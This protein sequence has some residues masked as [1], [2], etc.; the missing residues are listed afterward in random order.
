MSILDKII[1]L[2]PAAPRI[3]IYGKPGIGKSTLASQFPK[4]LFL[5]TE[6][7]RLDGINAVPTTKTFL[8]F[9]ENLKELLAIEDFPY[10]TIVIDS[11]SKL[12]AQITKHIIDEETNNGGNKNKVTTLGAACG[13]YGKGYERAQSIHRAVKAQLDK[14]VDRG[15]AVVFIAHLAITK[16]KA[17]DS[18][19]YDIYSI[20]MNHDKSREVYIDDVDAVLFGRLQSFT[21]TLDSGKNIVKS[22]EQRILVA[23]VNDV[24]VAKNRFSMPSQIPMEFEELAKYIP[25]YN[26]GETQ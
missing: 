21:D 25:F 18:D 19:D 2:K 7:P 8:E 16:Y 26:Q 4:P 10:E 5:L 14:F 24:N 13:G 12:D 6:D 23:S 9:W 1:T 3:T 20:I 22:T 15:I 11:I 17:P